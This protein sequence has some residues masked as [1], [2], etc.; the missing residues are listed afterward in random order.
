MHYT[1][2]HL[3]ASTVCKYKLIEHV[4]VSYLFATLGLIF[5]ILSTCVH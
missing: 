5:S 2:R 4:L 3:A 1:Y